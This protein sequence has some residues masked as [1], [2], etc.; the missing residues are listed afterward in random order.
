MFL[1]DSWNSV[2]S[3]QCRSLEDGRGGSV[4]CGEQLPLLNGTARQDSVNILARRTQYVQEDE[5][6]QEL[7]QSTTVV[8]QTSVDK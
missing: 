4:L 3:T 6:V 8:F 5:S 2:S 7:M 1:F